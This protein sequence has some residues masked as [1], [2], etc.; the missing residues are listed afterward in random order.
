MLFAKKTWRFKLENEFTYSSIHLENIE[1][2]NKFIKISNG[3]LIIII[4]ILD[5]TLNYIANIVK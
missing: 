5:V 3:I 2:E 4:L 1:F